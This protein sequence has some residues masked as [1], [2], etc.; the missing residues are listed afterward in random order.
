MLD[1]IIAAAAYGEEFTDQERRLMSVAIK[2]YVNGSRET[3]RT[4]QITCNK[5]ILKENKMTKA[6]QGYIL[7]LE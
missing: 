6:I 1:F 7:I 3:W 2:N 5:E 4:L